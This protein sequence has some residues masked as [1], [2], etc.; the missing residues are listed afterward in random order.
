M[1][2]TAKKPAKFD[3]GVL[4]KMKE[5]VMIRVVRK[6]RQTG[7]RSQPLPLPLQEWSIADAARIEEIILS[8]IAGGGSYEAQIIDQSGTSMS[9][10]FTYPTDYFPPKIAPLSAGSAVLGP[11]TQAPQMPPVGGSNGHLPQPTGG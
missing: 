5:P 6:D 9:W 7:G 2:G 11:Q 8:D 10:E 1:A 4:Q 3:L